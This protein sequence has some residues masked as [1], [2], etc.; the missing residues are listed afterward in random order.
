MTTQNEIAELLR[1][2]ARAKA[3]GNLVAYLALTKRIERLLTG[4]LA[5]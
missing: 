4:R 3:E 2:K 1:L 5:A